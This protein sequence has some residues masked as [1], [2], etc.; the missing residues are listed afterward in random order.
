LRRWAR[1]HRSAVLGTGA[2]LVVLLVL[3]VAGLAVNNI[4][5]NR[6]RAKVRRQ[7]E[8]A[9]ANFQKARA[10]VDRM[11]RVAQEQLLDAPH[12]EQ[13]RQELLQDAVTFYQEFLAERGDDPAVRQEAA[14]AHGRLGNLQRY[15]GRHAEAE[16]NLRRAIDMLESEPAMR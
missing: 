1:R 7:H 3:A 11:T 15:L 10:A 5:V 6:E 8:E 12:M 13:I 2:G 14:L 9:I 4:L 16:Q